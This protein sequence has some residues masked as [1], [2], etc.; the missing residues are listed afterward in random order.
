MKEFK[1]YFSKSEIVLWSSSV[2]V[3]L[4]ILASLYDIR[5]VS[6]V[7]CFIAFFAN[8]IYGFVSWRKMKTRQQEITNVVSIM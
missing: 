7:V 1:D 5:Y 2:M 8:D 4:W 3:I 6:V